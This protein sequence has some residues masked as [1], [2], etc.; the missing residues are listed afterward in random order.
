[1]KRKPSSLPRPGYP[2]E[3]ERHRI[4]LMSSPP[5]TVDDYVYTEARKESA[6]DLAGWYGGRGAFK[7]G[8][9]TK[10]PPKV[11]LRAFY[12]LYYL[13]TFEAEGLS[14]RAARAALVDDLAHMCRQTKQAVRKWLRDAG[15]FT[16]RREKK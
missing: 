11:H 14:P 3:F 15:I 16:D 13:P 4:K 12:R 9:P 2:P 7:A 8:R 1:M 5:I 10:S 6:A